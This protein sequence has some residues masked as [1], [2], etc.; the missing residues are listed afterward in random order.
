[1]S[2]NLSSAALRSLVSLTEK[3]EKLLVEVSSIEKQISAALDGVSASSAKPSLRQDG[4][5]TRLAQRTKQGGKRGKT[6]ELILDALKEVGTKGSSAKDLSAKTGLK[7]PNIYVWFATTGKNLVEKA[8]PGIYR[9]KES[10][11]VGEV[12]VV[13]GSLEKKKSPKKGK[14]K[15]STPKSKLAGKK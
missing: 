7:I 6:K 4:D 10:E 15:T 13:T 8:S 14:R 9:L 1:M 2:L 12:P 5:K 3:R 11:A